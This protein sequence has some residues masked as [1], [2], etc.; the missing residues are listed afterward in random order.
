MIQTVKMSEQMRK[1]YRIL[2][3]VI[4]D[5]IDEGEARGK[6]LGLAEGKS[7][8][9]AEGSRQKA[10][11]TAAAFKRFGFDIDKIAEGTGLSREEI[12]KL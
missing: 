12:E 2:P 6:S 11:E 7:L 10:L 8:G 1:E 4:M 5:A 9:L 3:A